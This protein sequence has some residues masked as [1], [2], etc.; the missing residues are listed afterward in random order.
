[1][2]LEEK[3]IT[4]R[5]SKGLSQDDLANKL[6]V[7]R[8]AVYKW[9]A[10][11]ATPEISKLKILSALYNVSIDNLLDNKQDIIYMN[12]PK[13]RY[14]A[15]TV[16]KSLDDEAAE[17]DNTKLLP[18]EEKKFKVRKLVLGIANGLIIASIALAVLFFILTGIAKSEEEG[19]NNA[20]TMIIFAILFVVFSVIKSVLSKVIYPKVQLARTYYNQEYDK[21]VNEL[22]AKYDT[23]TM[24]QPDL[25]AWFVYDSKSNSFGFYFDGEMQFFCPINNYACLNVKQYETLTHVEVKYFDQTGKL[26]VYEFSLSSVRMFWIH[27]TKT[28]ED[29]EINQMQLDAR[30]KAIVTEIKQR[31][32]IEKSRI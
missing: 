1:M 24:L 31:L 23:V 3:L 8:Q 12:T 16:K 28:K 11:Q 32:D 25:L 4:L 19:A 14:G 22:N 30:T 6:D 29:L 9:E 20:T 15:V 2:I 10:G 26:S 18:D 21:A 7:S 5:K 17:K 27:E 13:A